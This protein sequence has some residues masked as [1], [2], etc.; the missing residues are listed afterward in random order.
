MRPPSPALPPTVQIEQFRHALPP[1]PRLPRLPREKH[2]RV[3]LYRRRRGSPHAIVT[4]TDS[5]TGKRRDYWLGEFNTPA[6]REL[7]FRL[8][9]EWE[10]GGRRFPEVSTAPRPGAASARLVA[11]TGAQGTAPAVPGGWHQ[12]ETRSR[13][14]A[15]LTAAPEH[16]RSISGLVRAYWAWAKTYYSGSC[17]GGVRL[18]LRVLRECYGSADA[19]EFGPNALRI[20]REAMIRGRDDGER[21]RR[22]WCRKTVNTRTGHICRMFR[23]AASRELV[24]P[25]IYLALQSLPPL[26][27]GRCAARDHDPIRP[28]PQDQIDAVRPLVSR[29]VRAMIDLQLL[30]AARPGEI[31]TMRGCDLD[32]TGPVW[33]YRPRTHKNAHR[34]IERAIWLGPAA[35]KVLAEFLDRPAHQPLFSAAEAEIERRARVHARRKTPLSCGNRPGSNLSDDPAHT[36]GAAYT[37]ASY[38]RAIERACDAAFPPPQHLRPRRAGKWRLESELELQARLSPAQRAELKAW[39]DAHRWHPNQLRHNAATRIRREFGLEAAALVLGHASATITD[40]VYAERD[41]AKVASIVQR[42][43]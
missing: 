18:A 28:A 39:R 37:L 31:V 42:V 24:S 35:Q 22:P 30:T 43:G 40:A 15:R 20:V 4:L 19:A 10:A 27:R 5:A 8:I 33:C 2:A 14:V 29:Q 26:K 6:S 38:R 34:N 16:D 32:T 36:V 1:R 23:W 3:P 9:A 17:A 12:P 21:P 13:R 7:Y 25:Q 11:D 41:Q